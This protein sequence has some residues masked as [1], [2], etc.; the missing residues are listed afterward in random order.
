MH[1]FMN[2]GIEPSAK[3]IAFLAA[4]EALCIEHQVVLEVRSDPY[5]SL[6]LEIRD[7]PA[8]EG[9][10]PLPTLLDDCTD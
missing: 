9:A 4:L 3:C 7:F 5:D 6:Y 1:D 10:D 2:S 8:L